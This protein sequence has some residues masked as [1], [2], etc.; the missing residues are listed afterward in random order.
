MNIS[1]RIQL[2]EKE[3]NKLNSE[4][5]KAQVALNESMKAS[6]SIVIEKTPKNKEELKAYYEKI[7]IKKKLVEMVIANGLEELRL[8]NRIVRKISPHA[9]DVLDKRVKAL[10]NLERIIKKMVNDG[11]KTRTIDI[12]E[13]QIKETDAAAVLYETREIT[14]LCKALIKDTIDKIRG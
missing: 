4:L 6:N 9:G 11:L 5:E 10:E 1:E 3:I 14:K 2:L 7:E 13:L 12:D 8:N